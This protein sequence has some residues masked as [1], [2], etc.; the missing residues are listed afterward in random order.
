MNNNEQGKNLT[1]SYCQLLEKLTA[2]FVKKNIDTQEIEYRVNRYASNHAKLAAMDG[3]ENQ[4][5]DCS[6][7]TQIAL[8]SLHEIDAIDFTLIIQDYYDKLGLEI[9]PPLIKDD[10][11]MGNL[12]SADCTKN[13]IK[14][15]LDSTHMNTHNGI[16]LTTTAGYVRPPGEL[17][18]YSIA[19]LKGIL[20]RGATEFKFYRGY[21]IPLGYDTLLI[22]AYNAVGMPVFFGDLTDAYP[23]HGG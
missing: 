14:F 3:T 5:P 8:A 19:M 20:L 23:L 10:A 11:F 13:R 4:V 9:P 12:L 22:S 6:V 2:L 18:S 1:E 21:S 7:S 15:D 17:N 16:T